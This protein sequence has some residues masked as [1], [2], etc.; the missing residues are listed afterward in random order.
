[1]LDQGTSLVPIGLTLS[2]HPVHLL[3]RQLGQLLSLRGGSLVCNTIRSPVGA[4]AA[5]SALSTL[6]HSSAGRINVHGIATGT[7]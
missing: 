2:S 3:L 6:K 7:L 4:L 5:A 1:M